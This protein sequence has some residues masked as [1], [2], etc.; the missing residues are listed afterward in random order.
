MEQSVN[1]LLFTVIDS[2]L[3]L[4]LTKRELE[5]FKDCYMLPGNLVDIDEDIETTVINELSK[6]TYI[7]NE[8][9][10]RQLYT[11][12]KKDRVLDNRVI[13]TFY[14]SLTSVDNLK[15]VD[16]NWWTISKNTVLQEELKRVSKLILTNGND[17][18]EYDI[19][20]D[21]IDNYIQTTSTLNSN[22][23]LAFDHIKTINMAMDKLQHEVASSGLLFNL[24]PN[25]F[26]LKEAQI[27]YEAIKGIKTDTGNF[28]R[29]I[30]KMLIKT[31]NVTKVYNKYTQLYKFNPMFQYLRKDL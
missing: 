20:D 13:S 8:N 21:V 30:S 11:L 4:L 2:Q 14:I 12:G 3:K 22:L 29:D 23:S 17:T 10:F 31:G 24:L 25:E 16:G 5:P 15:E 27:A 6:R 26:T 18:I 28:R 9:Y 19:T 7:T 1:I